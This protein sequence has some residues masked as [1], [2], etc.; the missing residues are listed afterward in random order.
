MRI[1][2]ILKEVSNKLVAIYLIW[3]FINLMFL[4]LGSKHSSGT[5]YFF[6]F[7]GDFRN[8]DIS[9][10]IIYILLPVFIYVIFKLLKNPKSIT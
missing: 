4:L 7:R 8:Y 10:F 1:L 2:K 9:E 6:P 3:F 5:R